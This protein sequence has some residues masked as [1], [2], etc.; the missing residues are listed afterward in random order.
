MRI[1]T[2][3]QI[4]RT[5]NIVKGVNIE[6]TFK[7]KTCKKQQQENEKTN[8][9]RCV[10]FSYFFFKEKEKLYSTERYCITVKCIT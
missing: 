9:M 7:D 5:Q 10:F 1:V 6:R 2:K 4:K 3:I 8:Q